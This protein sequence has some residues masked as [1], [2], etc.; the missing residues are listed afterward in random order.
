[1]SRYFLQVT[2]KGIFQHCIV[3]MKKTQDPYYYSIPYFSYTSAAT[4]TFFFTASVLRSSPRKQVQV[5]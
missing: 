4:M 3:N 2:R 5:E 1:M